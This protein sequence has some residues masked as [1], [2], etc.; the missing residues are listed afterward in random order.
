MQTL[1]LSIILP[2]KNVEQEIGGILR[3]VISQVNGIE[4]EFLI[5]DMGSRDGTVLECVQ[6]IKDERLR[7][8]VVQNGDGSVSAALNTGIQKA[9][10]DYVTFIFARRLYMDFLKGYL[11]T[12]ARTDADFVFGSFSEDDVRTAERRALSKAVQKQGGLEYMKAVINGAVRIDISAVLLR[13]SF[14]REK[15]LYFHEECRYGYV[16]EFVYRCLL[17]AQTIVQSPTI[18]TRNAVFELKRGKTKPIGK[19]IFEKVEAMLRV[20]LI[21]RTSYKQDPELLALFT[22]Q[23]IPKTVMNCVDVLLREG[24]GYNAIRG[25]LR[26]LEYDKLLLPGRR[27]DKELKRQLRTWNLI[28]WMYKCKP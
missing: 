26:L 10:G 4:T 7:G 24:N 14:L 27:T 9:S 11:D 12:A 19:D 20:G 5:V 17:Q 15:E 25:Q 22:D 18:L 21:L 1:S 16:E 8:F 13:K 28:P 6:F 23:V 2:V 3:S